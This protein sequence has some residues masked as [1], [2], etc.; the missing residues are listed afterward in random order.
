MKLPLIVIMAAFGSFGT[1]TSQVLEPTIQFTETPVSNT[2]S[3]HICSDGISY[4]TITGGVADDGRIFKYDL[5]G[6]LM[7]TYP[8]KLDMRGIMYSGKEKSFYV[9][10]VE[11]KLYRIKDLEAGTSELVF[12]DFYDNGQSAIALDT[13]CKYFYALDS[14]DLTIYKFKTADV[15][16]VISGL[17]CGRGNSSGAGTVAVTD[18][19]IYTWDSKLK[20]VFIYNHDGIFIKSVVLKYGDYGYSLSIANGLIFVNRSPADKKST[21]YGYDLGME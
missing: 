4:Y 13:K 7:K 20:S 6:Q 8:M 21:W 2:H 12:K 5:Q 3:I 19:Y 14:G 18:D 16:K 10:T 9:N 1:I 15:V 17:K 11:K